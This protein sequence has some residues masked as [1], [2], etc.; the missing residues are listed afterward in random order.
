VNGTVNGVAA[1]RT[2]GLRYPSGIHAPHYSGYYGNLRNRWAQTFDVSS[3]K[4]TRIPRRHSRRVPRRRR[5]N[6]TI[7]P[8]FYGNP[9]LDPT[10]PTFG[11]LLRYTEQSNSSRQVQLGI[12]GNFLVNPGAPDPRV[13]RSAS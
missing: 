9:D 8:V 1:G 11:A 5:F 10:S 4:K 2:A 13:R 6:F 3:S 7:Y 12:R